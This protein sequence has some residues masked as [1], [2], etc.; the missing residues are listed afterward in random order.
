M[1]IDFSS[2]PGVYGDPR[3]LA[4]C[5]YS[6]GWVLCRFWHGRVY[7]A[8]LG[9]CQWGGARFLDI[10]RRRG[11]EKGAEAR[12]KV[13][14][15]ASTRLVCS[16]SLVASSILPHI[17]VVTLYLKKSIISLSPFFLQMT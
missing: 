13:H 11:I 15:R 12:S 10:P 1:G 6:L 3:S 8:G 14:E 5:T 7:V 16:N 4:L 9:I 2:E 17:T